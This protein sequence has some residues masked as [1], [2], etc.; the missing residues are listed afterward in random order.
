MWGWGSGPLGI[1]WGK[2]TEKHKE[3]SCVGEYCFAIVL[4]LF[5]EKRCDTIINCNVGIEIMQIQFEMSHHL[6]RC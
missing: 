6:E 2:R 4:E 3:F 5:S 1:Q